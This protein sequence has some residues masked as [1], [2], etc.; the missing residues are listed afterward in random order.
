M[1]GMTG[2]DR[3][4]MASSEQNGSLA[5]GQKCRNHAPSADP[6]QTARLIAGQRLKQRRR[7]AGLS[8]TE[9]A[10]RI[11]YSRSTISDAEAKGVGAA[12]LWERAD[13][14]LGAGGELVVLYAAAKAAAASVSA[15]RGPARLR[16]VPEWA[17][18]GETP[19][20]DQAVV[21]PGTCPHCGALLLLQT[22]LAETAPGS[23]VPRG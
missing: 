5:A 3:G 6:A 7:T 20:P 8:Q 1:A 2:H 22:S 10:R 15:A 19:G 12:A 16:A 13:L 23:A 9:L 11:G 21:S 18:P 17:P 14:E 4:A